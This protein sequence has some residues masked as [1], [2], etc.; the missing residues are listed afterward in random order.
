M[1]SQWQYD[2]SNLEWSSD[3]NHNWWCE[4][5]VG[6][7]YF[8][9]SK[10]DVRNRP[11]WTNDRRN[12]RVLENIIF[13]PVGHNPDAILDHKHLSKTAVTRTTSTYLRPNQLDPVL[14]DSQA[15]CCSNW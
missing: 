7:E 6:D 4:T 9:A 12:N 13:V 10:E 11:M 8:D 14:S 2:S 1:G 3:Y 15:G 5:L